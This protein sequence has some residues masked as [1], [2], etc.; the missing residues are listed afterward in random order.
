MH[1]VPGA[2]INALTAS[3]SFQPRVCAPSISSTLSPGARPAREAGESST[4]DT[5]TSSS[6]RDAIS[7]PTPPYSPSVSCLSA[8]YA[9]G[10]MNVECGSS[11]RTIP[12]MAP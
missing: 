5:T 10:S 12:S 2:P 4:G 8:E 9:F 1:L 7:R 3:A 6:P 11:V